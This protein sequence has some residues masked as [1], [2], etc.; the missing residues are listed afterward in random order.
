MEAYLI[1]FGVLVVCVVVVWVAGRSTGR[2]KEKAAV[3]A[4]ILET[5]RKVHDAVDKA[6]ASPVRVDANW[7]RGSRAGTSPVDKSTGGA[8]STSEGGKVSDG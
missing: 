7:M 3:Q 1:L 4:A 6:R 2:S 5:E 8:S